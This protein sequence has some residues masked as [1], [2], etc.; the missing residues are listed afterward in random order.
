VVRGGF[1]PEFV[2]EKGYEAEEDF[3]KLTNKDYFYDL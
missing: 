2:E 3:S 1:E